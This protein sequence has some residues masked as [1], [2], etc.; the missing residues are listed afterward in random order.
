MGILIS[1]SASLLKAKKIEARIPEEGNT[2]IIKTFTGMTVVGRIIDMDS[3]QVNFQTDNGMLTIPFQDIQELDEF[4]SSALKKGQ[5]WFPNPNATRLF[6]APTG[7]MQSKG[8]GYF[9]DYYVLLPM[10]AYGITDWLGIGGG[11][12]L[13]PFI[14]LYKQA[15]YIMPRV[16]IIQRDR[17]A[18]CTGLLFAKL[19]TFEDNSIFSAGILYSTVTCGTLDLS[20]TAGTG[21]GFTIETYRNSVSS[22][23]TSELQGLDL[24]MF[25]LGGE[26]RFARRASLVTENW[27]VPDIDVGFPLILSYGARLIGEE[28]S[29]DL[30]F[31]I[32]LPLIEEGLPLF[33]GVPY[34][35]FV[36]T[37]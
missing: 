1:C 4:P 11:L 15:V 25:M 32:P 33:P 13:V 2:Q 35:D 16:G 26:W 14:E 18:W 28:V 12:S 34:V 31:I 8:S 21:Y 30:G 5:Y 37:F 7:R 9:A 27:V 29:V 3:L 19:P 17:F 23:W 24:P 10:A 6:F 22:P 20:A 36:Y